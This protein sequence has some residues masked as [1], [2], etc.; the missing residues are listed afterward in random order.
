MKS[1]KPCR[2]NFF[3]NFKVAIKKSKKFEPP[4]WEQVLKNIKKM[5]SEQKAPVDTMGCEKCHDGR[6]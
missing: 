1:T 5:R 4:N 2:N 6:T 3:S